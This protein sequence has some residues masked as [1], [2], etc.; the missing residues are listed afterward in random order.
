MSEI[1]S[2][3]SMVDRIIA[4]ISKSEGID[5]NEARRMLHKYVCEGKC[6]WYK[7]KSKAAGFDRTDLTEK[8]REVIENLVKQIMKGCDIEYAKWRIHNILCPGH[9]RP[10][11]SKTEDKCQKLK[12]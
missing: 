5:W 6:D 3:R 11:P 2:D 12:G 9:P 1:K 8:K 4:C 10:R 7:T